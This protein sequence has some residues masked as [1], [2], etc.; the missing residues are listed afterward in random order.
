MFRLEK[1]R[2]LGGLVTTYN[3]LKR[4]NRVG[5]ADLLSLVTTDGTQ[6]YGMKVCQGKFRLDIRKKVL[7]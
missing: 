3:F 5:V 7:D 2:L 1:R 6:G 4:G